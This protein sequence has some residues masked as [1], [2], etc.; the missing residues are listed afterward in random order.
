MK[1]ILCIGVLA[2]CGGCGTP[3]IPEPPSLELARPIRDLKAVRKANQVHLSWSVPEETED[4]QSFRHAGPTRICRSMGSPMHDCGTLVIELPPQKDT[5]QRVSSRRR[6]PK[7]QQPVPPQETYTDQLSPS[8]ELQSP[9][10]NFSY[11]VSVLNSYGRSAGLSNQVQV[12]SAATLAAPAHLA[13]HLSAKGV[14][15]TWNAVASPPEISGV[16][17]EYRVYR[18]DVTSNSDVIAGEIPVSG[19]ANS[20]FLD[21]GFT[22]EQT[23][24][25]RV[26]VVTVVDRPDGPE[27]VEGDDSSP[28]R[29]VAHDVFPPAM[30]TGLQA[31]FSGPGQKPFIDLIW[32]GNGETDLAGYNVYRRDDGGGPTKINTE[33]VKTPAFRDSDVV[34]GH[35]YFYSISAV[36]ARSNESPR[37]AEAAETVFNQ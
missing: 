25:Y 20:S 8:L 14:E 11:A 37:S 6:V 10:S 23:Y 17:Y 18:R 29:I 3:G 21:S 12:P 5:K 19:D 28:V 36:D 13:G 4:H 15:L 1:I 24:D 34:P 2:V 35:E 27:Q 32:A 26:T 30:P 33:L 31:I 22:W 7:S 16:K 9:T